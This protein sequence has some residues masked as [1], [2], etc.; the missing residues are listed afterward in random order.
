[1]WFPRPQSSHDIELCGSGPLTSA[2]LY[3]WLTSPDAAEWHDKVGVV[4]PAEGSAKHTTRLLASAGWVFKTDVSRARAG[5]S[6]VLREMEAVFAPA[7]RRSIWH[8][9]KCWFA[10]RSGDEWWPVSA[11]PRLTTLRSIHDVP[12]RLAGWTKMLALGVAFTTE[13]GQ[14]LDLNP[15]NFGYETPDGRLYYIDDEFYVDSPIRNTAESIAARLPEER[16]LPSEAWQ[17]W[18][19]TLQ[20]M[21]HGWLTT[22]DGWLQFL[23]ALRS[24]PLVARFDGARTSLISGLCTGNPFLDPSLRRQRKARAASQVCIFSDVHG[25]LPALEAVLA[26]AQKLNVDGYLCLGDVVGYGPFPRECIERVANLPQAI[27]IRGNHDHAIG[28][29]L[30]A[31]DD[32]RVARLSAA[33]TRGQLAPSDLTWLATLPIEHLAVPWMAVH[34][35]PCDPHRFYAYVYELTYQHNLQ[36]LA[37]SSMSVCFYGHTHVQF[38][39][40]MLEDG[41]TEKLRPSPLRLFERNQ[42]LLLNPGS[43]GQP[44]DGD[45]AAAFA[46]WNRESELVTFHRVAYDVNITIRAIM[47]AD[48]P[49]DLARRLEVGR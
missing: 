40:R 21:L 27:V 12:M 20:S 42:R 7:E 19:Q 31:S 32:N 1:M 46:I 15:A 11:A 41:T 30:D 44:R 38:I 49:T 22:L 17:A 34:G 33:W 36:H 18:G 29:G 6:T 2:E 8:P 16:D 14:V 13:H 48:L 23:D 24:Y 28:S 4:N 39:H 47:A 25:N 26:E 3:D 9:Q 10:L 35:A 45:P 37:Q 43:V 5:R